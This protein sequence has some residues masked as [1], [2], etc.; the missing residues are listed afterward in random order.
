MK[1]EEIGSREWTV[2]I[3]FRMGTMVGSSERCNLTI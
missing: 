1:L 2:F 3:R